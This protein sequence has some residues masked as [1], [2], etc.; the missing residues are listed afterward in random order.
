MFFSRRFVHRQYNIIIYTIPP[1]CA[2]NTQQNAR[3]QQY[4]KIIILLLLL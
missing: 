1:I 2:Y 4:Y 3:G